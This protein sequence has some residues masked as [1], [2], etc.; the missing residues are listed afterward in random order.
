M[1]TCRTSSHWAWSGPSDRARQ[2]ALA[3]AALVAV[4]RPALAQHAADP[5][6]AQPGCDVCHGSHGTTSSSL[7]LKLDDVQVWGAE[8]LGE[9]SRSCL[10]CHASAAVRARQPELAG[11]ASG[12]GGARLLGSDLSKQHLVGR[13]SP[14][15]PSYGPRTG[16]PG[17]MRVDAATGVEC[18]ACHDPH[19]RTSAI[20]Q[21]QAEARVC[22]ECHVVVTARAGHEALICSDCHMMHP[23]VASPRLMRGAGADAACRNCHLASGGP[24]A[25]APS[26]RRPLTPAHRG[27]AQLPAGRCTDCHGAH[28]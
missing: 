8:N 13:R 21:P 5:V 14:L 17:A 6:V 27:D 18:A 25:D 22:G 26:P 20:P 4:A 16:A 9:T 23:P 10:R 2:L 28:R 3:L 1:T 12:A 11:R 15:G 7:N 19:D 24:G